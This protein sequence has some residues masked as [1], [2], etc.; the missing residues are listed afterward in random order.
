LFSLPINPAQ[1]YT[2]I[3][4]VQIRGLNS[5]G[6]CLSQASLPLI[7]RAGL[8]L[9]T[10]VAI[11]AAPL[12]AQIASRDAL[13]QG[14]ERARA[15]SATELDSRIAH[16]PSSDHNAEIFLRFVRLR[17]SVAAGNTAA[18]APDLQR[19]VAAAE[20]VGDEATLRVVYSELG[21]TLFD[22]AKTD[23]LILERDHALQQVERNRQ[24]HERMIGLELQ[25]QEQS[26]A[27]NAEQRRKDRE[28]TELRAQGQLIAAEKMRQQLVQAQSNQQFQLETLTRHSQLEK[29]L[30][31][32]LLACLLLA[33]ALAWSQWRASLARKEQ[34]LQDPLTGLKNRRFLGPFMEHETE[35]LRRSGLSA[36]ILMAD[37]DLFKDVN[38]KWGHKV[39]DDA[40]VQLAETLRHCMR[41]SD[42]ICRWGGEEFV[43]VCPESSETHVALICNRIRHHLQQAPVVAA[44]GK[45]FHL[46]V[47]IGAALFSPGV[48]DEHWETALALADQAMYQV[49]ENGRDHWSLAAPQPIQRRDATAETTAK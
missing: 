33:V 44:G 1:A 7:A 43:I 27:A 11:F 35:R 19:I 22:R 29:S 48:R 31:E 42:V 46:T 47:S 18:L 10:L 45:S 41:H 28:I 15:N 6:Q 9:L 39:G 16:L 4:T 34:A 23:A 20:A 17:N 5:S 40:L 32:L 21:E 2:G 13:M 26:R 24:E 49:K 12:A 38:D 14:I 3:S 8:R 25:H 37:I 30:T 36:I